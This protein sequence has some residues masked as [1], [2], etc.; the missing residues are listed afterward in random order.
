MRKLETIESKAKVILG[1]YDKAINKLETQ[2]QD[3]YVKSD[4]YRTEYEVF[5]Y[6]YNQVRTK[7][8]VATENAFLGEKADK[9]QSWWDAAVL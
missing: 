6:L 3:S 9:L 8:F 1:G 4:Q 7:L 5:N 2:L